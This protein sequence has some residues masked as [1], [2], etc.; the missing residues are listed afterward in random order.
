MALSRGVLGAGA[1]LLASSAELKHEAKHL[2]R[3]RPVT[4]KSCAPAQG[5]DGELRMERTCALTATVSLDSVT[6]EDVAYDSTQGRHA[7][8]TSAEDVLLE[9]F[10][11][12][13]QEKI[14]KHV[15]EHR[16]V[17]R[18][19]FGRHIRSGPQVCPSAC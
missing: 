13:A 14:T 16:G 12:A 4:T 19:I 2:L 5:S 1:D 8:V 15:A 9:A 10:P 3:V 7:T 18:D 6:L 17:L 11:C